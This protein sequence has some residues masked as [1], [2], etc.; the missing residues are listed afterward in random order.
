MTPE[1][2]DYLEKHT[3][4]EPSYLTE[5]DRKT[6]LYRLN[7]RMCSGHVQGRLLKML[8]SMIKPNKVLELG[9][10]TGYS[11][12]CMAEGLPNGGEI[13]TIEANDELENEIRCNLMSSPF[14]NKV[15]LYIGDAMREM[16][17]WDDNTFDMALMDA[18]KR[19]YPQY[20]KKLLKLVKP[21]GYI[22]ADNTL[23]DGHVTETDSSSSQ[24]RGILE[25]NDLVITTP[26]VEVSMLPIRDGLTI[27]RKK[28][29]CL[30]LEE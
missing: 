10:F 5:I 1:L 16:E 29:E 14:G 28:E 11:A 9:T 27:I 6:N 8:T 30:S 24:T 15:N 12:L 18:D 2:E 23:W 13:H 22:I 20:F 25:F 19:Q 17:R 21:G 7:G 4:P 3:S 26:G